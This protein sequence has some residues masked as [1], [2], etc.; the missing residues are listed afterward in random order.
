MQLDKT[1]TYLET[2]LGLIEGGE[3]F[4]MVHKKCT[5]KVDYDDESSYSKCKKDFEEV[6]WQL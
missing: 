3:W 6:P 1:F 5:K 4:H 2:I